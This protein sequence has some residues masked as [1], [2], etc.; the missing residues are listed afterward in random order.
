MRSL[1]SR[2]QF[3]PQKRKLSKKRMKNRKIKL[4]KRI[5]GGAINIKYTTKEKYKQ[6]LVEEPDQ[7]IDKLHNDLSVQ[8][9]LRLDKNKAVPK[10]LIDKGS[11]VHESMI[12]RQMSPY[13]EKKIREQDDGISTFGRLL[14]KAEGK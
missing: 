11:V 9:K 8:I 14:D 10:V 12:S 1:K 13:W 4:S 3:K 6:A 5:R 7:T 2:K